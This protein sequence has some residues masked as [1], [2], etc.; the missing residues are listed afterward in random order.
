MFSITTM[1]SSINSPTANDR[2]NRVMKLMVKPIIRINVKVAI[3][4]VGIAIP[5]MIVARP[6]AKKRKITSMASPPP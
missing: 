3:I 4:D 1:A 6:L 5:L 2:P